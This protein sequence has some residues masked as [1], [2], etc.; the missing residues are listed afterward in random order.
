METRANRGKHG[1][2]IVIAER[3]T[4]AKAGSH[5]GGGVIKSVMML[6]AAMAVLVV[7]FLFASGGT[8]PPAALTA[9]PARP[10]SPPIRPADQPARAATERAQ[11]KT[12]PPKPVT[13]PALDAE[14]KRMAAADKAAE[15][16]EVNA[17]E[18][19]RAYGEAVEARRQFADHNARIVQFVEARSEARMFEPLADR[20]DA[21]AKIEIARARMQD[22]GDFTEEEVAGYAE[23]K[24]RHDAAVNAAERNAETAR[25][26]AASAKQERDA[27]RAAIDAERED[28][29]RQEEARRQ[30][31]IDDA[32][33]ITYSHFTR[34]ETG[35]T[36]QQVL[37][38][39]RRQGEEVSRAG[40]AG[41]PT[42]VVFR[43]G[44]GLLSGGGSMSVTF[45]G[46]R[47][48]AKEQ[49]GLPR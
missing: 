22:A 25:Q 2:A 34:V 27:M 17:R 23:A 14:A 6:M 37:G 39:L 38:V 35:M 7:A 10:A 11:A 16:A 4:M 15:L 24:K 18:A 44:N 5:N 43:W 13:S 8:T 19:I 36:Y 41:M 26:E 49:T 20:P 48:V 1:C 3:H 29:R 28:R 47:V 33:V 40:V 46:E 32:T 45:Q 12:E 9:T 21:K 31:A 42:M 30:Q